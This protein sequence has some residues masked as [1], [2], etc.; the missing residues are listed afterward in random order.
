M[1]VHLKKIAQKNTPRWVILLIDLFISTFSLLVTCY[2]F[3]VFKDGGTG[4]SHLIYPIGVVLLFRTKAFLI[5]KSYTGILKYT[6]TQDAVRI[7]F[8]VLLSSAAVLLVDGLYYFSTTSHMIQPSIVIIDS[9]ILVFL[10]SAFRIS[11]KLLYNYYSPFKS[12]NKKLVIIYGAGEAGML[13]KR[14]LEGDASQNCKVIAFLDD[15]T[16]LQ[17]KTLDGVKILSPDSDFDNI[18]IRNRSHELVIAIKKLKPWRKKRI[19][20]KC[21]TYD[22]G[23]K[24]IPSVGTWINGEFTPRQIKKVKIEDLLEREPIELDVEKIQKELS[25]EVI[26]ITGAAGSIGSRD[27]TSVPGI[28]SPQIDTVGSG[29]NPALQSPERIGQ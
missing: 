22:I 1:L 27:R 5:T 28:Q 6:S 19:I 24:T 4:L 26:L 20:E 15:N 8:A 12:T 7:F 2:I 14:T 9:F 21:L 16:R 11:F 10:L 13:V 18:Q 23:I 25:D 3:E 17:G 29:R